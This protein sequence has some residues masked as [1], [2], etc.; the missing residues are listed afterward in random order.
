MLWT[1]ARLRFAIPAALELRSRIQRFRYETA[2][3][4]EDREERLRLPQVVRQLDGPL[5]ASV[6]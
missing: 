5:R 3:K 4:L 2:G 1:R 6:G